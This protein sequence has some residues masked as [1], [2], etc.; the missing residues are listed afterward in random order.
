MPTVLIYYG[1]RHAF[2]C[3]KS[4]SDSSVVVKI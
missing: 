3:V 4:S 1:K 2:G